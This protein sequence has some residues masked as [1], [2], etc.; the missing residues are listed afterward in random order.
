MKITHQ[1]L[2]VLLLCGAVSCK[3]EP[4]QEPLAEAVEI[5]EW[6]PTDVRSMSGVTHPRGVIADTGEDTPGYV[7]FEPSSSTFTFLINKDGQVVH[8]WESDLNSM[9]SYLLPNGH[10]FRMERDPDF[11]TFA[12]GGQAGRILEYD[13]DGNKVWDFKYYSETEL[14]HHDFE[15]MPNGNILAISYE[16]L[17]PEEAIQQGKNPQHLPK[18]GIWLDKIVEVKPTRPE[19][20]EIVWEWHMK[21]HLIQD[22]DSTKNNFG[23]IEENPRK[24]NINIPS[25]EA[26]PP[27]TEEQVNHMKKMGF[28]T[29][30]ATADNQ[31]SDLTHT[32]AISYNPEL[33]QIVISVPGFGEVYVIDHSTSTEEAKGS[34][35]GRW[36]HGGDL[37]YRWGNPQNYGKGSKEDQ[38]LFGQHD[39]K[40][41][42]AGYPGEGNLMVYNNDIHNPDSKYPSMF[43]AFETVNSP[44]V[45]ISIGDVGNY[46]A[47]YE[48]D[49]P[50]NLDG[51]YV[52]S[53]GGTFAPEKPDW[54]YIAPD[55][56]SF[57]SAFIS[58]AQRLKNGNTL[59]TQGM[60]GRIFE[61]N[62][63]QEIVWEYWQPYRYG[64]TLP[65]GSPPQPVGPFIYHLFRSTLFTPDFPAF[66]G[67]ELAP[68]EPQPEPFVFKMPPPP[69]AQDSIPGN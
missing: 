52:P 65:D 56:Y 34:S 2:S 61:L 36:G 20:G 63:Q 17:S 23:S 3:Q 32:N 12:A 55:K 6:S 16:A 51:S 8:K 45:N 18:A 14:T 25:Y 54:H 9:N 22:L 43:A 37:L 46:S 1:L 60:N 24:I 26:G 7:L 42:P 21:D 62:P 13:W 40:W 69:P 53:D 5:R 39:V 31:G 66:E 50:E 64:Y 44:E 57:Y 49:I 30:N 4:K 33:D 48:W 11:P 41:I 58:G 19:G 10:L 35:G 28:M 29:S 67:R 68:I 27:M 47:V 59:V 15:I 38:Q